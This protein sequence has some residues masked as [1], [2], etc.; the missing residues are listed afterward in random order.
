MQMTRDLQTGDAE[1]S[2]KSKP[3]IGSLELLERGQRVRVQTGSHDVQA[4]V[5]EEDELTDDGEGAMIMVRVRFREESGTNQYGHLK[6]WTE[7]DESSPVLGKNY[8]DDEVI[9]S[10]EV[11]SDE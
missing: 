7:A 3:S 8:D 5:H 4:V 10:L 9:E 1:N 2:A 11:V 6:Y